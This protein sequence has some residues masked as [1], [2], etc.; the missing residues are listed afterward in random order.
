MRARRLHRAWRRR[1]W[2]PRPSATRALAPPRPRARR[3]VGA[4]GRRPGLRALLGGRVY[5]LDP[6][7]RSARVDFRTPK[8]GSG[9]ADTGATGSFS[10]PLAP[11]DEP[12]ELVAFT[13]RAKA[14]IEVEPLLPG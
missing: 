9:Y 6:E 11:I 4:I 2:P 5:G 8:K 13:E 1:S 3:G 14:T 10:I 7:A 12:I